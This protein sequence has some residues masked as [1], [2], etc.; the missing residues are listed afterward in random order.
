M[1]VPRR[2]S[3][4]RAQLALTF[5]A[6]ALGL[7]A[8]LSIALG[9]MLSLQT[10]DA[11]G[12]ALRTISK[13]VAHALAEDLRKNSRSVE[14]LA[15][16]PAIWKDGL[17]SPAVQSL[18][19][20]L[21]AV[22]PD[23]S[24][25]GVVDNAG[26]VRAATGNLLVGRDVRERPWFV[27]GS[28]GTYV[29]D[30]HTAKLLAAYLPP[31]ANG[32]PRRFVD[33]AAPILLN[34]EHLGVL[35][36][37]GSW[38]W[39]DGVVQ[40]LAPDRADELGIE[41]FIFDRSGTMIY[42]SKGRL[43]KFIAAGQRPPS[44]PGD[45]KS[46]TWRDGVDYLTAAYRLPATSES[47]DLGWTIITRQ[48][49][50]IAF[51]DAR[52]GQAAALGLGTVAAALAVMLAWTLASRLSR[53]LATIAKAARLVTEGTASTIPAQRGSREVTELSAALND[54]TAKL[55][56]AKLELEERVRARTAELVHAN[57][58][59][60]RLARQ[61]PLTGLPNR[62][63]FD[64]RAAYLVSAARRRASALSIVLVD[65]DHFKR[66]NDVHGHAVG[67]ATLVAIA[68]ELRAQLRESD[69]VARIGGEEF[70]VLLPH[71]DGAGALRVAEKI[72]EAMRSLEIPVVGHVTVSCGAAEIAMPGGDAAEAL[73]RADRALY[74]AKHGGRDQAAL[75]G[76]RASAFSAADAEPAQGPHS[77]IGSK[78]PV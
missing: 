26:I 38:D 50:A 59:L 22:N 40:K 21:Q 9:V 78:S 24:W 15:V 54:M 2:S 68:G 14:V 28:R 29:G 52:H 13:N 33:F 37:H 44:V 32:E 72:V 23:H 62:R 64:E 53:P 1:S 65:A 42:A 61:D 60:D 25:I 70:A 12:T 49:T 56:A 75:D 46:A 66:V 7:A 5:G 27:P 63:A 17:T 6:L 76:G 77:L 16:S 35:T 73:E 31:L 69:M 47:I 3:S 19:A 57:A 74:R 48:P 20:R 36:I 4:L 58:E 30:V 55:I 41:T 11:E 43:A 39:T 67:D 45:A 51:A 71:T 18:L 34:G 8:F 10:E